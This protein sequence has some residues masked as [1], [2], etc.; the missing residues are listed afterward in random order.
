MKKLIPD[1][2]IEAAY[3]SQKA[4]VKA[5]VSSKGIAGY[6]IAVAS[7]GGQKNM[8]LS[9]PLAGVLYGDGVLANGCTI[10]LQKYKQAK[11]ETEI[12]YRLKSEV[13]GKTDAIKV[14]NL[15]EEILPVFEI[16]D[17]TSDNPSEISVEELISKNTFG[18]HIVA[19]SA[20]PVGEIDPNSIV[21]ELFHNDNLINT[22]PG[23]AAM[24]NQWEALAVA[25][26]LAME[27]GYAPQ[28]GDV[29]I[30]GALGTIFNLEAGSYFADYGALGELRCEVI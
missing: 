16:P 14:K 8:G 7:K 30:T 15:V 19:G 27:H 25:L 6:K 11:I 9:L 28:K 2:I 20:K 3:A 5:Q 23:N 12:G 29:V 1:S 22:A 4:F 18:S 10:D 21:A 17:V 24:D 13:I 26:N